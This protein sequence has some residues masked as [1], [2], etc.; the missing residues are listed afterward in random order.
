VKQSKQTEWMDAKRRCRMSDEALAMAKELGIGPLALIKNVPSPSQSWKAPVEDWVRE[1][2]AKRFGNRRSQ[3]PSAPGSPSASTVSDAQETPPTPDSSRINEIEVAREALL[4]QSWDDD[5]EGESLHA[6]L[7]DLERHAPVS[8]GEIDDDNRRMLLRRDCLRR[9]AELFAGIA[10]QLEF[11]TRIVLFGSV[12]APLKKEVPRF[13]RLRRAR[14]A[15]WHECKDVDLAI[16]VTD[17]G[18]LRELKRAISLAVNQWQLIATEEH[19]P[20]IPHHQVDVFLLE[21]GT[22]R[23]RGN[24]C[25]FG[26]CPKGKPECEIPGCGAQ[27]FLQLYENFRFDPSAPIRPPAV[28][29]YDRKPAPQPGDDGDIPF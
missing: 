12:A 27:P 18:R 14:I 8:Q 24:L 22:G 17:L 28:V 15:V 6:A 23:Y 3:Q 16:W 26:Q 21:P 10:A 5:D 29:L 13:S 4:A 11:V 9:F 19:L 20:G 25:I 1:L 7:E 2:H